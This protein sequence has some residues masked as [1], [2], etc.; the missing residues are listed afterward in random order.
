MKTLRTIL[1]I[2][3]FVL[4]V[5]APYSI[6][7]SVEVNDVLEWEPNPDAGYYVVYFGTT[8]CSYTQ[9]ST[10]IPAE[11]PK[12]ILPDLA[13]TT[14]YFSVKAFNEFGNSSDFSDEIKYEVCKKPEGTIKNL[15][16][17][18]GKVDQ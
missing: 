9:N 7:Y 16:I 13:E 14:W 1:S 4:L 10:N 8:P 3:F 17:I 5:F 2:L 12:F 6:V 15:R 11:T 18:P